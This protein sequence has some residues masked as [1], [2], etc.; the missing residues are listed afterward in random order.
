MGEQLDFSVPLWF[1]MGWKG[2][3]SAILQRTVKGPELLLFLDNY[4]AS[5]EGRFSQAISLACE[6][7]VVYLLE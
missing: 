2:W 3:I 7:S 4:L 6:V 1:S 5:E